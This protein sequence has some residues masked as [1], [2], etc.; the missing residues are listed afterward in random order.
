M[1]SIFVFVLSCILGYY[2]HQIDHKVMELEKW[3]E[4]YLGI[5]CT[6]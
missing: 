6:K 1:E 5:L 2:A 4:L 3:V